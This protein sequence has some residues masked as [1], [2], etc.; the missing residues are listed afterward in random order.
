[1]PRSLALAAALLLA[2]APLAA[3]Q[4]P[5]LHPGAPGMRL[6][7]DPGGV[8]VDR[9]VPDGPAARAGVREGDR[10][11]A[12]GR[13]PAAGLGAAAVEAM[14]AGRAGEAVEVTLAGPEGT[15]AL[16][17]AREDVFAPSAGY[18]ETV[19]GRYF[20]VH[21]RPA[22]A[23]RRAAERIA[24]R[25]ERVA[26]R[27]LRGAEVEGRRF[28]LYVVGSGALLS[29]TRRARAEMLPWWAGWTYT[30]PLDDE[31]AFGIPLA[32]LRFGPP[33]R[34]VAERLGERAGWDAP[35]DEL[36]RRA[37]K[38]MLGADLSPATPAAT[39][40][41]VTPG[42]PAAGASLRAYLR[43]RFGDRRF[44][45]LWRAPERFDS[46]AARTLGVPERE[47]LAD[48]SSK[49][50]ALGPDPEAGPDIGSLALGLGYGALVLLVGVR[51]AG[52]KEV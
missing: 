19:E 13:R 11:V 6:E 37:V 39:L 17:L 2:L 23:E 10:I 26:E 51:V 22:G 21:H 29:A 18:T 14:L 33:G 49:V 36:H 38:E 3:A 45:E 24:R 9:L 52:R 35:P 41:R 20:V 28:H 5:P 46:A 44:G 40:A 1:M 48:W 30:G 43:D 7:D 4:R 42:I 32:Y 16:R 31:R 15:R 34:G 12:V 25:A 27:D 8:R 50:Y 47:L